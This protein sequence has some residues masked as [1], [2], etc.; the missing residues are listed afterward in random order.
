MACDLQFTEGSSKWK[1][2]TKVYKFK[3][4][5]STYIHSDFMIGFAGTA[6]AIVAVVEFFT[7]PE[8]TKPPKVKDLKGL[9]LTADG[10]IFA[11]DEYDKWIAMDQP[12]ASIGSG[13]ALAM[14]A[15]SM[16][17]TPKE[18]IKTATKYDA[19]TGMGVKVFKF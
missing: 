14:G 19:F 6:G 3:A 2:K 10:D 1:G 8:T 4:H 11:F 12:Y 18:A 9:V 7:N 17:C 15:M 16:G 5:A 13:S